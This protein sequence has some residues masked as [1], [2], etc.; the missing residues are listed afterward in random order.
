MQNPTP[1]VFWINL[2]ESPIVERRLTTG[3]GGRDANGNWAIRLFPPTFEPYSSYTLLFGQLD[4]S[5][6]VQVMGAD[7]QLTSPVIV[8]HTSDA[9]THHSPGR[10]NGPP[11]GSML[12]VGI[13]GLPTVGVYARG[14][15]GDYQLQNSVN[16]FGTAFQSPTWASFPQYYFGG[17]QMVFEV[18][19]GA[20]HMPE[21]NDPSELWMAPFNG[22]GALPKRV[23][24]SS[25]LV[26]HRARVMTRLSDG[27]AIIFYVAKSPAAT[28]WELRRVVVPLL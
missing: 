3:D 16:V 18:Q 20:A 8:Q 17:D 2:T 6:H 28:R 21:D 25:S 11:Y 26:R 14:T 24:A 12:W 27:A 7:V 4:A 22:S 13:D 23:S 9:K 15:Q 19:D 10:L 1:G 5:G